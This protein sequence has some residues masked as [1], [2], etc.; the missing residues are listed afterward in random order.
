M[1]YIKTS[2]PDSLAQQTHTDGSWEFYPEGESGY[3]GTENKRVAFICHPSHGS[4]PEVYA[5][6]RL[7]KSSPDL[8]KALSGLVGLIECDVMTKD[9]ITPPELQ[10]AYNVLAQVRGEEE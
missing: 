2:F 10:E 9:T 5:N 8:Y 1:N 6:V 7:I 3:I 4:T